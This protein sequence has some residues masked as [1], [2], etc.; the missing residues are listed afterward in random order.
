MGI[1]VNPPVTVYLPL[2]NFPGDIRCLQYILHGI[3]LLVNSKCFA[4][5][6]NFTPFFEQF[7]TENG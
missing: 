3:M 1:A 2:P 5:L 4:P 6:Y 7:I